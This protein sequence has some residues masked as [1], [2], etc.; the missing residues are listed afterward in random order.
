MNHWRIAILLLLLWC[1]LTLMSCATVRKPVSTT[2]DLVE[3]LKM[4]AELA[5]EPVTIN[6][7]PPATMVPGTFRVRIQI[8]H[9]PENRALCWVYDGP[10]RNRFC[11]E[12]HGLAAPKT[13]TVF[14]FLRVPGA[15][16]ASADLTRMEGGTER[17]YIARQT[18]DV[19]GGFQE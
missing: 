10:Q 12:L 14:W 2:P 11:W 7:Y 18:F 4:L 13:E 3:A 17:H 16:I 5:P 9:H 6:V 8:A 1:A 19:L 15:Y